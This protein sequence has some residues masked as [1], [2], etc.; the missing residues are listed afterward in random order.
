MCIFVWSI[1]LFILL[2][3][4]TCQGC[5][6]SRTYPA[7]LVQQRMRGIDWNGSA[8]EKGWPVARLA[9]VPKIRISLSLL[10]SWSRRYSKRLRKILNLGTTASLTASS[11]LPS[12]ISLC[13]VLMHKACR[14]S[15][16]LSMAKWSNHYFLLGFLK[17]V[18]FYFHKTYHLVKSSNTA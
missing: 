15:V 2:R 16:W 6:V 17:K 9:V 4:V 13:L 1:G 14:W 7:N 11:P 18:S 10:L 5:W 3:I 12:L 8:R